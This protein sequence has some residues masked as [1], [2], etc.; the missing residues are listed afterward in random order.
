MQDFMMPESIK[1]ATKVEIYCFQANHLMGFKFFAADNSL[2][3][4]IGVT[5]YDGIQKTLVNIDSDEQV[6]GVMAKVFQDSQ[7]RIYEAVY[8]DF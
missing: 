1:F 6:V 7:N 5:S 2:I 8:T 4:E 3:F